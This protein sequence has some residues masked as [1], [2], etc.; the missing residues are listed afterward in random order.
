MEDK[1]PAHATHHTKAAQ[2]QHNISSLDWPASSPD[3][4]PIEEVWRRMKDYIYRM[5]ERHTTVP[6]MTAAVQEAWE[7]IP[8]LEIRHLVD[9]IL[10]RIQAVIEAQGGHTRF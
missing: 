6:A 10:E 1:A 2:V 4:N 3:L 5:E 7:F 8:D 9:T